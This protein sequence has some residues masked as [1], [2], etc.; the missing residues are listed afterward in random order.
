MP[1]KI[2][3]FLIVVVG[4]LW[5]QNHKWSPDIQHKVLSLAVGIV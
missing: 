5:L 2:I 1:H 4:A 3:V